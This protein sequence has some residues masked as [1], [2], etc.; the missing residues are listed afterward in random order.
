MILRRPA[1]ILKRH[2]TPMS[3]EHEMWQGI[4]G[5]SLRRGASIEVRHESMPLYPGV[6]FI[7]CLDC[8]GCLG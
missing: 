3:R 1:F 5:A 6:D 4:G 7:G 2:V 8:S